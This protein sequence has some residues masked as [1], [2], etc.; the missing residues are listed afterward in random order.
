MSGLPKPKHSREGGKKFEQEVDTNVFS[1]NMSTL[2]NGSELATGDPIFCE[3]CHAAFNMHIH[4]EE[5]KCEEGEPE[6]Q[7][8]ACEFCNTK[9]K[10]QIEPE[11]IPKT[12]EVTYIM[13]AAAQVHDKQIIG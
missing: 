8:W 12:K 5:V 4:Y 6:G 9:N 1:I 3:N 13:E 2:K 10:I 7:I 11:E